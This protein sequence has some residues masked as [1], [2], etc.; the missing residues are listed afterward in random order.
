MWRDFRC[1]SNKYSDHRCV[2][3]TYLC[4]VTSLETIDLTCFRTRVL[5]V[6]RLRRS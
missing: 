4:Y 1:V 3:L 2:V 6:R 5:I